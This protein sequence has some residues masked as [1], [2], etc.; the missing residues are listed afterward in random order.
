MDTSEFIKLCDGIPSETRKEEPREILYKEEYVNIKNMLTPLGDEGMPFAEFKKLRTGF[1]YL[2]IIDDTKDYNP[3]YYILEKISEHFNGSTHR[4][5]DWSSQVWKAVIAYAKSLPEYPKTDA[6]TNEFIRTRERERAKAAKRL[7]AFGAILSVKDC[8]LEIK[9]LD[10]VLSRIDQLMCEMGGENVL[11]M[12]LKELT[13]QKEFGRY[14]VPHQGNQP[15]PTFIELEKPYG[16][17][18]NLCLKHL[19]EKGSSDNLQQKWEELIDILK[20]FC[21]AVYD[22]QKF[23]IWGDIIYKSSEVVRIVHEM[24]L[25]FNL[26]TLPQ[27][28]VSFA[29]EWCRFL[30]KETKRDSRCDGLLREKLTH[31]EKIMDWV[32]N[33][34]N[35]D[36]CRHLRKDSKES[37]FF[38]RYKKGIEDCLIIK[39]DNLNMDFY[40]PDDYMKVNGVRYPVIETNDE[41]IFLPKPLVIWNWYEAIYN[42]IRRNKDKVLAKEIG[43][44]IEDFIRNKMQTHGLTT[45]T[46]EYSYDGI[47][48]EVDFLIEGTNADVYIESKKKSLSLKAQAGD[49][50]YIWGDLWE[51]IESQMQC[52]RLENGVKNFGPITLTNKKIGTTYTYVWKDKMNEVSEGKPAVKEDKQ[53]CVVKATMTLKEYG[54][55]QDNIVLSNIIKSLVGT[56]I[57]ATFDVGDTIHT[58]N[59]QKRILEDFDKINKALSDITD[60]YNK[61]GDRP[62]FFCRFYSMEQI[63]FLI[64]KATSQDHFVDLLRGSFVSTGTENFWNEYWVMGLMNKSL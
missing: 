35:N 11:N 5:A 24:I 50:Y 9:Q 2:S 49:D 29:L 23:D 27:T 41:Y 58:P 19:K 39:V 4:I 26:Y 46:G 52:A 21:M 37:M 47:D 38:D 56:K 1:I 55:M 36:S 54:P 6:F 34:S 51:F 53:R 16:Y 45:H 8:D 44:V 42:L 13:Y 3:Y 20:D 15:M 14:L 63:Y 59:D 10:G 31:V 62:T 7:T 30:C 17:L 12:L 57:N 64:R 22:S 43:Y 60:Y 32:V 18:F 25:R 28:N 33:V 48:G 61:I 40:T